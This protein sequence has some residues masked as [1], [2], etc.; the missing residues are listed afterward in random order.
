MSDKLINDLG[1]DRWT[2]IEDDESV[3]KEAAQVI[4]AIATV[5]ELIA[6]ATLENA[7]AKI[8][9]KQWQAK[10]SADVALQPKMAQWRVQDV[11]SSHPKW[12][13]FQLAQFEAYERLVFLHGLRDALEQKAKLIE[14]LLLRKSVKTLDSPLH[15]G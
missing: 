4:E 2:W 8:D 15:Q 7:M 6:D 3:R 14:A 9:F 5:S 10:M 11:V 1:L 12:R 13:S